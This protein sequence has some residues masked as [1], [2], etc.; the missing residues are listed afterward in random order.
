[1]GSNYK[2][3]SMAKSHVSNSNSKIATQIRNK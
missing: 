1:M 2:F 3:K